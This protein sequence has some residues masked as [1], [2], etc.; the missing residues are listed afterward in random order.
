VTQTTTH[1]TVQSTVS[2]VIRTLADITPVIQSLATLPVVQVPYQRFLSC[3]KRA[4]F[5]KL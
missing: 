1:P 5:D 3:R 2:L 4:N